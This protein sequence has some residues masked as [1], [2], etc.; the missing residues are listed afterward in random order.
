MKDV[1]GPPVTSPDHLHIDGAGK[2]ADVETVRDLLERI[3]ERLLD[4]PSFMIARMREEDLVS[5]RSEYLL[6]LDPLLLGI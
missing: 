6:Q 2:V 3:T 5:D 4:R 1:E